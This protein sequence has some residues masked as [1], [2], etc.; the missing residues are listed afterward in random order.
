MSRRKNGKNLD[1]ATAP[2]DKR[3]QLFEADPKEKKEAYKKLNN[4]TSVVREFLSTSIPFCSEGVNLQSAEVTG[5][6]NTLR[7]SLSGGTSFDKRHMSAVERNLPNFTSQTVFVPKKLNN[8]SQGAVEA[9]YMV[10]DYDVKKGASSAFWNKM[11]ARTVNVLLVVCFLLLVYFVHAYVLHTQDDSD[12]FG[13]L[14]RL[15]GQV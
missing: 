5:N 7:F 12:R 8:S 13:A 14:K 11:R 1:K 10:L 6:S 3:H 9:G 4:L 15:F 2:Q